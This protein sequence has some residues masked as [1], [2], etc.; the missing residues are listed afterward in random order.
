MISLKVDF[1]IIDEY[2]YVASNLRHADRYV[3][4]GDIVNAYDS[5][6]NHCDAMVTVHDHVTGNIS[7]SLYVDTWKS[8]ESP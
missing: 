5:E 3:N 6:G 4:L 1:S 2:G 8:A 7:V